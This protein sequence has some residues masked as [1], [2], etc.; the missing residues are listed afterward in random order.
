MLPLINLF[1]INKNNLG[2]FN[3]FCNFFPAGTPLWLAPLIIPIEIISYCIRPI[4]MGLR[5]AGNLI[6]GHIIMSLLIIL[7]NIINEINYSKLIFSSLLLI[8]TFYNI[9]F[10]FEICVAFIQAYVFSLLTSTFLK[11]IKSIH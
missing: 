7:L 5:I 11:E 8:I 2:I 3:W 10:F 9:L 6:A 4:S 1:K